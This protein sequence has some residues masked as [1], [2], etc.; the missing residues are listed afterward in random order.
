M[1]NN[2]RIY[3]AIENI[4]QEELANELGVSRQT[5]V[6]I[7]ND[8]YN[9]SLELAFKIA[10]KFDVKIEDIFISEIWIKTKNRI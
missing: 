5:I 10:H 2:L 6:A 1:R 8:K 3:R 4:T 9:P 7:E